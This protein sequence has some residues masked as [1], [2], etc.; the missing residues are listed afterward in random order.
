MQWFCFQYPVVLITALKQCVCEGLCKGPQFKTNRV[1][2]WNVVSC[3]WKHRS[4][5]KQYSYGGFWACGKEDI[6]VPVNMSSEISAQLQF[7]QL[8]PF[9]FSFLVF[10]SSSSF[11]LLHFIFFS[12]CYSLLHVIFP[13]S[14]FCPLPSSSTSEHVNCRVKGRYNKG[15]KQ[16]AFEKRKE[17]AWGHGWSMKIRL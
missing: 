1:C 13:S 11:A 5:L 2:S 17:R 14:F 9:P 15:I 16:K 6:F 4:G 7:G 10:L 8:F 12:L 3:A